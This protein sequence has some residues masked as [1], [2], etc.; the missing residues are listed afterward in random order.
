MNSRNAFIAVLGVAATVL[1]VVGGSWQVA[2]LA[3]RGQTTFTGGNPT[4]VDAT[5]LRVIRLRFS[6]GSR[7]HWHT[8]PWGQ[9]LMIEEGKGRVQVRG[10]AIQDLIPGQP[11]WTPPNVEH[12]HGAAPDQ[13]A[14]QL[15]VYSSEGTPTTWK[16]PVSDGEYL[17]SQKR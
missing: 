3:Q 2:A 8:H 11:H 1:V 10:G 6:K 16:D 14:L 17:G 5:T 15:T 9:L 7:T 4:S 12:W 13:D